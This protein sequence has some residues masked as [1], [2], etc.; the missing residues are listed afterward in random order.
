MHEDHTLVQINSDK[1]IEA[2]GSATCQQRCWR[3]VSIFWFHFWRTI[4][5]NARSI[6]SLQW[7]RLQRHKLIL[8]ALGL[9]ATVTISLILSSTSTP[10]PPVATPIEKTNPIV[11]EIIER[12]PHHR[13][14]AVVDALRHAWKG[15]KKLAWGHDT[16]HPVYESSSDSFG[17]G[18]TIIDS[19]DTLYLMG[20]Q[21]GEHDS[22]CED[23]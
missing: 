3:R 9:L 17:L 7:T 11:W 10:S 5:D 1:Y 14:N 21:K 15:Y 2:N 19:L 13:Q 16:L 8:I 4:Y 22:D 12:P 23:A 18:F 20:M 6:L